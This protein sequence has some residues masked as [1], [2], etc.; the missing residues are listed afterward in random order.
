MS[1]VEQLM[2]KMNWDPRDRYSPAALEEESDSPEILGRMYEI[3]ELSRQL[4]ERQGVTDTIY[5]TFEARDLINALNDTILENLR[6][7]ND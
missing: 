6:N 7:S 1:K 4:C 5:L 3:N 2:A